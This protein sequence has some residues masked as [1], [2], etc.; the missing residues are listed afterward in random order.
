ME[1]DDINIHEKMEM[2]LT[3]VK[4]V[5]DEILS[6]NLPD[7]K[8]NNQVKGLIRTFGKDHFIGGLETMKTWTDDLELK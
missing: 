2:A 6:G 5:Y 4:E 1:V 3:L 8:S 7:T